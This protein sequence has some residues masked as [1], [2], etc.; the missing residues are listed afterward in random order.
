VA[1]PFE[2]ISGYHA[3]GGGNSDLLP[4]RSTT[5]AIGVI[6]QPAFLD[7]F[8]ATID[9]FDIRVKDAVEPIGAQRILETCLATGDA[10][11]CGRVHRDAQGSLWL[12][13]EGRVDNRNANIASF[14]VRGIDISASY[15]QR[16]HHGGSLDFN[17]AA[18][19]TDRFLVDQ[20]GLSTPFDCSGLYGQ[21]CGLPRPQWRHNLRATWDLTGVSLSLFW[22]HIGSVKLD[23]ASRNPALARPYHASAARIPVQDYFD[24]TALVR[25][26]NAYVFRFGVR[27]LFDRE[28]PLVPTG[29]A[30][31]CGPP[32]CN[33]NT[34]P[35]LYDPLGRYVFVGAAIDFDPL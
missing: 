31:A 28:P 30:G 5:H 11:F 21:T 29:E 20:G 22:R 7:G 10:F 27:N 26:G 12:S 8:N 24:L 18:T 14:E 2:D 9:W 15:T 23:M 25:A 1:N 17:A 19:W 13:P 6:L 34:F 35:Q 33:G 3:V 16:L 4:E 32:G